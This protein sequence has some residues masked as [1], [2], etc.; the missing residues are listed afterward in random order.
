M[1][2]PRLASRSLTSSWRRRRVARTA[3]SCRVQP[4]ARRAAVASSGVMASDRA[5]RPAPRRGLVGRILG[6]RYRVTNL[7]S[8]GANTLV[9]DADDLALGR[10]VTIKLVRPDWAESAEFRR[11]FDHEMRKIS[12]L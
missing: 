4:P 10:A 3:T 6:D 5:D 1:A 12:A 9:A 2:M 7:V 8:A 11:A